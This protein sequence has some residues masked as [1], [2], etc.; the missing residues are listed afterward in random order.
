MNQID[1]IFKEDNHQFLFVHGRSGTGKT[2]L[3]R[4][5]AYKLSDTDQ[6]C[7]VRFMSSERIWAELKR[8]GFY[9]YM[10]NVTYKH[11]Q[12]FLTELVVRLNEYAIKRD[13][14]FLFV[15]DDAKEGHDSLGLLKCGFNANF[16]ILY[17]TKSPEIGFNCKKLM[18]ESFDEDKC[19]DL[20]RHRGI[21][22]RTNKAE[23]IEIFKLMGAQNK[24]AVLPLKLCKLVEMARERHWKGD[25]IKKYLASNMENLFDIVKKEMPLAFEIL[26]LFSYLNGA[27]ISSELVK[28]FFKGSQIDDG[29]YG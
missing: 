21:F 23:W 5:Y 8:L 1:A 14:K 27:N 6:N 11:S 18:L 16:K 15:I 9:F 17:T 26:T 12:D 4:Q 22:D 20:I 7:I 2:T 24:V 25:R 29:M 19:L 13:F 28:S 10:Q 3:A